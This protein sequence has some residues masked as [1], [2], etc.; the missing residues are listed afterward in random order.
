MEVVACAVTFGTAIAQLVTVVVRLKHLWDEITDVPERIKELLAEVE[1][2]HLLFAEI[3]NA[4]QDPDY[5]SLPLDFWTGPL[6]QCS[7][8]RAKRATAA[9]ET[10]TEELDNKLKTKRYGL[11]RKIVEIRGLMGKEKIRVLETRLA[12]SV[13]LLWKSYDMYDHLL[14]LSVE[15]R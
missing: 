2:F 7:L 4:I 14:L 13:D 6:M 5:P 3:R 15:D 1:H 8:D 12:R 10:V 9:L 11:Q